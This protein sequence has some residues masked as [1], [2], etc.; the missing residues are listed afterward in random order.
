MKSILLYVHDDAGME[1]RLQS[2]LDVARATGGHIECVTAKPLAALMMADPFGS[3]FIIP[4]AARAVDDAAR[5]AGEHI[6]AR[7]KRED[8]P[9]SLREGDGDPLDILSSRARMNDLIILSLPGSGDGDALASVSLGDVALSSP[10]PVLAVPLE[11]GPIRLSG[12]AAVAWNGS[13]EAANAMRAALPLLSRASSVHLVTVAEDELDFP[14]A[15]AATYLSRHGIKAEIYE[16][17]ESDIVVVDAL[18]EMLDRVGAD[19]IVM[20]AYGRGRL[21]E[22][23]FGGV[24]RDLLSRSRIPL[25]LA[26]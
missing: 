4:E 23:L 6:G 20:G 11:G 14:P 17:T 21:R 26:H 13:A 5:E 2:A 24:T 25:L 8:V 9:W 15:E 18:V 12:T 7:M 3:A 10:T 22:W 19:W 16:R 1:S